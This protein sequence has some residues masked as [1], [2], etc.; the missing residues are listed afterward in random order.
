MS[1]G[2]KLK[3]YS[4]MFYDTLKNLKDELHKEEIKNKLLKTI[5]NKLLKTKTN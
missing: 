5:K 1:K 3:E 2:E 4:P